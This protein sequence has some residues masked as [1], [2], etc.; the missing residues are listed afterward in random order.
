M[1]FSCFLPANYSVGFALHIFH[2]T[3]AKHDMCV[4][5]CKSLKVS[6]TPDNVIYT[7]TCIKQ[8]NSKK[9]KSAGYIYYMYLQNLNFS[10]WFWWVLGLTLWESLFLLLLV[11]IFSNFINN[12]CIPYSAHSTQTDF[13]QHIMESP[14][15]DALYNASVAG[16]SIM[17]YVLVCDT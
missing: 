3:D 17:C 2:T 1:S 4:N 10:V 13:I 12:D 9:N 14:A 8:R 7:H 15:T 11:L 16:D 5:W 6:G